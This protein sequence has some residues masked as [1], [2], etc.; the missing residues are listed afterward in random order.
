MLTTANQ[1]AEHVH[2]ETEIASDMTDLRCSL[3]CIDDSETIEDSRANVVAS[4]KSL[5]SMLKVMQSTLA[6]ID[7]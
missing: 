2:E 3:D 4:I 7:G 5:Q 6:L 1:I